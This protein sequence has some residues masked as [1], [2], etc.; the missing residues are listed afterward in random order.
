MARKR[1]LENV[2]VALFFKDFS[3][4]CL[5]SC[6]G[7][8]VAGFCTAE[9]LRSKGI[10]AFARAVR[11]NADIVQAIDK[12]NESH[13]HRLTHVVISAPW[14]SVFDFRQ[15]L[16][17][18]KDIQFVVLSHSNVGFLQADP[19]GVSLYRQYADLSKGRNLMLGGNGPNFTEWFQCAYGLFCVCLPNLYPAPDAPPCK[20]WNGKAIR[21]GAFGAIRPEKNFMTAAGAAVAIHSMMDVPVELNMSTGGENCQS[22]T[23]PAITQM[24]E[25][26]PGF[27]LKR[28]DWDTWDKFIP[29][30]AEMDLLIQPSFTES[31]CMI[32]ADGISQGVPSVVSPVIYWAPKSW[33]ANPDS[34]MDIADRGI[35]LLTNN[36][37]WAGV[38]ALK[39]HNEAGL[40]EWIGFLTTT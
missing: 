31:F 13:K 24:T 36:Q 10:D 32:T 23:L 33:M 27:T 21:L 34:A 15:L 30:V 37:R 11:H 7:L 19:W 5:S 26:I 28:H 9:F 18:Y 12:Y 38:H 8:H 6:V 14:L 20:K 16:D 39:D 4:F 22:T 3:H 40:D 17:H 35:H 1:K 25:N 2:H 29:L